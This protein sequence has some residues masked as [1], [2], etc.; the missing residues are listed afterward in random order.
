MGSEIGKPALSHVI[1]VMS[2]KEVS[3]VST[4][5]ILLQSKLILNCRCQLD[6]VFCCLFLFGLECE[7]YGWVNYRC[8]PTTPRLS[9]LNH[10]KGH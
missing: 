4:F 6:K 10:L 5:S 2:T 1:K 7:F 3:T 9:K 8:D